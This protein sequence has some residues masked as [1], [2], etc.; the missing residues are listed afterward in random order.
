MIG[1]RRRRPRKRRVREGR[2]RGDTA[3]VNATE[4]RKQ[5]VS[6]PQ[7]A[8]APPPTLGVQAFGEGSHVELEATNRSTNAPLGS[9]RTL[10]FS[11]Q[12]VTSVFATFWRPTRRTSPGRATA[13]TSTPVNRTAP[14]REKRSGR[15]MKTP[16]P[17][18]M[19]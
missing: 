3:Q 19:P 18:A 17:V 5:H 8:H 2:T 10:S 7:H 13:A 16:L 1:K 12:C 11:R 15:L 6:P 9:R 14:A 4:H